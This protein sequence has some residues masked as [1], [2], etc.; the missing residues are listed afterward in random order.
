M[1]QHT[2]RLLKLSALR[3]IAIA[4]AILI[5]IL[6]L[7]KI[8]KQPIKISYLDKIEHGIAYFTLAF[9]WLLAFVEKNKKYWIVVGC[10]LYGIIIEVL[11]GTITTY[12]TPDYLDIIANFAGILLALLL[13]NSF[14]EK[15]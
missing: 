12:R 7:I 3:V 1:Q 8:G 9:F 11:Q 15:K 5:A 13:F 14:F 6:S 4:I 2:Q 10:L